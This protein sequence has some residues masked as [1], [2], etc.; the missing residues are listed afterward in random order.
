[1]IYQ[2]FQTRR[3]VNFEPKT[4]TS[5]VMTSNIETTSNVGLGLYVHQKTRSK[6]LCN[7]LSDLNLSVNYDKVC[8]I[9]SNLAK[10][11]I[12]RTKENGGIYKPSS[13]LEGNPVFLAIDN[14]DLQV[15][16]PDGK[17]QLHATA[18]AIYQQHDPDVPNIPSVK[19]ERELKPS[20]TKESIY[21]IKICPEAK[22][23]NKSYNQFK[24][25]LNFEEIKKSKESDTVWFLMKTLCTQSVNKVPTWSAY[26]S[27]IK[28]AHVKTTYCALPVLQGSPTDWSYLYTALKSA[29]N[30][31][32]TVSSAEKTIVS[33]DLQLCLKCIQLQPNLEISE[34]LI[35]RMGELHKVF[36]A[37]KTLG[38]IIDESG[39]EQSFIEARIYGPDTVEQ[40]KNGKHMKRSF[41]GFLTLYVSLYR[42]YLK[43]LIDQNF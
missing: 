9:K 30:L 23:E 1:M 6:N 33:L 14:S 27:L 17:G 32:T 8:N 13:I 18:T 31:N 41:E 5:R 28:E 3:Q 12:K 39:L 37:L 11:V 43:E 20:K 7:F 22:R 19:I 25:L 40:I 21:T 29:Q 10:S 24:D 42:I 26:N 16:T 35:F 2:S 15:D 34:Q 36:T 38:K 4:E